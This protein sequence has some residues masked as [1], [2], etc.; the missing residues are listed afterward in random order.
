MIPIYRAKK[1]DSEEYYRGDL[2]LVVSDDRMSCEYNIVQIFDTESELN[3][4]HI[5]W[6]NID[7]LT[8][9]ISFDSK[10]WYKIKEVKARVD[11][12]EKLTHT[13]H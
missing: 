2:T 7:E 9:E 12:C 6:V 13:N 3:P 5:E 1:I 4:Y 8:I 11:Y 10:S